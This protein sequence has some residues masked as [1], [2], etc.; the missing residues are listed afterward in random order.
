M[1]GGRP[2]GPDRS[3]T[4]GLSSIRQWD[5]GLPCIVAGKG[6]RGPLYIM[7]A[8]GLDQAPVLVRRVHALW[9][10]YNPGLQIRVIEGAE[11]QA[12]VRAEGIDPL[13]LSTQI[14]SDL[15]RIILLVDTGGIWADATAMPAMPLDAWLP[16][17]LGATGFFAFSNANRDRLLSSWFLAA[18]PGNRLV[19]RWRDSVVAYFRTPRRSANQAPPLV[20]LAQAW[21]IHRD[22]SSFARPDV[23]ARTRY[24]P[25]HILHYH[26]GHLVATDPEAAARWRAV[27]ALPAER[28]GLLKRACVKA[29]G[30]PDPYE[31]KRLLSASPVHKL[32]WRKPELFTAALD[33]AEQRLADG[34]GDPAGPTQP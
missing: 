30:H 33:A 23:A 29:G 24:H 8:Q 25:Y 4:T 20:R 22:A 9:A 26:F 21:R 18:E 34:G 14:L 31:V 11:V 1:V 10:R 5:T 7:W 32:N 3:V 28:A 13:G 12:L 6:M 16:G 2:A 17:R 19:A 15:I 27:P